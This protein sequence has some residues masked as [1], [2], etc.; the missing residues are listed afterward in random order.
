MPQLDFKNPL[1]VAQV[2]WLAIIFFTL[3]LLLSRW[4]LPQVATVL[5]SRA[6][7]IGRDLEAARLAKA[8][9]DGAVAEL[10]KATREAQAGAQASIAS[11]V[12]AAK[13]AAATRA[14][15]L[16]ATLDIQLDQAEQRIAAAREGAL[17]ALREVATETAHVVVSRLTGQP[18]NDDAI[19]HEVGVALAARAQA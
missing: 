18:A 11:A 14:A 3:Y 4:A 2:V 8:E 9:A 7:T 6:A 15:A 10:T 5:E 12:G 1:T 19:N 16:S 13:E 17:G